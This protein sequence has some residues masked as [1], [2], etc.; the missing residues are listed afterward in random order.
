MV[1]TLSCTMV[2]PQWEDFC[3]NLFSYSSLQCVFKGK[4]TLHNIIIQREHTIS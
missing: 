3:F 2:N 1:S 4:N